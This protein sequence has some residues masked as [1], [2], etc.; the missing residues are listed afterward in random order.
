MA[1]REREAHAA[2]RDRAVEELIE[3]VA[4]V[5]GLLQIQAAA[6]TDYFRATVGRKL[7]PAEVQAIGAAML[8]AYRWQYIVSGAKYERFTQ[9]LGELTS[10]AQMAR[11]GAALAPLM[12]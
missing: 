6:D 3:L 7:A 5:D 2:Q 12:Q 11:I 9:I 10:E 1:A 8:R 4:A